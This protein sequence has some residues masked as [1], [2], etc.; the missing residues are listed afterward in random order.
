MRWFRFPSGK[1]D[2]A[3]P[4]RWRL[5]AGLGG[6]RG[7]FFDGDQTLWDFQM[8]MRQALGRTL[9][10][11]RRLRPGDATSQL[12]VE[13][14][15][16]DRG[17]VAARLHAI[18][19]SLEAVRHAAFVATLDRIGLP[20]ADL[21]EH[22]NEYYLRWRFTDVPLYPDVVP[23]LTVLG[24]RYRLRSAVQRQR[25]PRAIRIGRGFPGRRVLPGPRGR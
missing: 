22:L 9:G 24:S 25:L 14:M 11:L 4:D 12:D 1:R 23:A 20:D 17:A 10:E 13:D 21:A 2:W 15:I 18:D 8:L 19:A 6:D 5:L 16:I 3:G 7:V